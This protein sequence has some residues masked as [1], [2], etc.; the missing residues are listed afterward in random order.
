MTQ[1]KS[2][3]NEVEQY[4]SLPYQTVIEKW[5]DGDGPY[6]V[7]KILEF[8][9]C[10]IHGDTPEEALR[11]LEGAKRDWLKTSLQLKHKIPRP[12]STHSYSGRILVRVTP[13]THEELVRIAELEGVSLNQYMNTVLA[14]AVGRD[15]ERNRV[16]TRRRKRTVM[17]DEE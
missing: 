4:A 6:Y 15:I 9:G 11:D 14:Q 10:M 2:I 7:A 1:T 3:H 13:T 12:L 16:K 5:D 8:P 17:K